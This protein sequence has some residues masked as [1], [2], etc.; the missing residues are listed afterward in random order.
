MKSPFDDSGLRVVAAQLAALHAGNSRKS[1]LARSAARIKSE[2]L[3]GGPRRKLRFVKYAARESIA[4]L[5]KWARSTRRRTVHQ[6]V[7]F[8]RLLVAVR[9]TAAWAT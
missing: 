5:L 2:L 3:E 9:A 4:K 1:F 8:D 6:A 7:P